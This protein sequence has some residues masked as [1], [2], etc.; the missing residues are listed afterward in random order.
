[1]TKSIPTVVCQLGDLKPGH[2]VWDASGDIQHI[3]TDAVARNGFTQLCSMNS[4]TMREFSNSTKMEQRGKS[5][6]IYMQ[7]SF[8]D[9]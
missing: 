4:G 2:F 1:M 8:A 9:C 3:V 7:A 5:P 6:K